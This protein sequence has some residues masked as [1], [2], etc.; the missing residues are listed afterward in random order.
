MATLAANDAYLAL[1]GTD[2]SGYATEGNLEG[3]ADSNEITAGFGQDWKQRAA[4]LRDASFSATIAYDV[5]DHATYIGSL[6]PGQV[7]SVLWCPE[8][9]TGGKPRHLQNMVITGLS[10]PKVDVEKSGVFY[11]F[12]AEGADTP[13]ADLQGGDTVP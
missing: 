10:G 4:G 6:T 3:S 12:S 8:G 11:E 9:N 1:G 7:V 2:V 13:T 5:A